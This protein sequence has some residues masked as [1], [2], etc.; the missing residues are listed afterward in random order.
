MMTVTPRK[1]I[2]PLSSY[3]SARITSF[4]LRSSRDLFSF[5]LLSPCHPILRLS[6]PLPSLPSPLLT[7]HSF[8]VISPVFS[9]SLLFFLLTSSFTFNQFL[10]SSYTAA[11][12]FPS[13]PLS[14]TCL[15]FLDT[16][17][18]LIFALIFQVTHPFSHILFPPLHSSRDFISLISHRYNPLFPFIFPPPHS[19]FPWDLLYLLISILFGLLRPYLLSS[20]IFFII[21]SV[22]FLL[23]FLLLLTSTYPGIYSYS[24]FSSHLKPLLSLFSPGDT[25]SPRRPHPRGVCIIIGSET[26]SGGS[27]SEV[28]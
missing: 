22:P 5:S 27:E 12:L 24:P 11:M 1:H 20:R 2:P 16:L 4:H 28:L 6:S 17:P 15:L 10:F 9:S 26:P 7:F 25:S 8:L 3:P 18:P 14:L 23:C 21:S 19:S 13:P